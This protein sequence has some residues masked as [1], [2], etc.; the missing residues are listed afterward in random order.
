LEAAGR[1]GSG[2]RWF[3]AMPGGVV[4]VVGMAA[5]VVV[6]SLLRWEWE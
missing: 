1:V 4:V 5:V 6:Q 2:G 3:C